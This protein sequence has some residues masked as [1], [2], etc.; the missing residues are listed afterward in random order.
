MYR[1]F[2]NNGS[3]PR[4]FYFDNVFVQNFILGD[5]LNIRS[6]LGFNGGILVGRRP[7]DKRIARLGRRS[8]VVWKHNWSLLKLS[9]IE[10]RHLKIMLTLCSIQTTVV[11]GIRRK[12]GCQSKKDDK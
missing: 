7:R 10:I 5:C 4:W 2:L 6:R 3:R 1:T 8:G 9:N 11:T 12:T